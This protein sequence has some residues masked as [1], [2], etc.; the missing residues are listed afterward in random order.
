MPSISYFALPTALA[1]SGG[2]VLHNFILPAPALFKVFG[3]LLLAH[4]VWNIRQANRHQDTPAVDLLLT[5]AFL[6]AIAL[7]IVTL[8]GQLGPLEALFSQKLQDIQLGQVFALGLL[9][10]S[11][12]HLL[13]NFVVAAIDQILLMWTI[14]GD[15]LNRL[16]AWN[17]DRKTPQEV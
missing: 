13:Q 16:T 14:S 7:H 4:G 2:E 1:A 17:R 15:L 11:W 10:L 6:G 3:S 5:G 8:K 12:W 9:S